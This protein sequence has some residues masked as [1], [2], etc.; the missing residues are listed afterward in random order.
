MLEK[1]DCSSQQIKLLASQA[2]DLDGVPEIDID[3][4]VSNNFL[5]DLTDQL[6]S[7][8]HCRVFASLSHPCSLC[9]SER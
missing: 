7:H 9:K 6:T 2:A 5:I 8:D 3:A 1:P 4:L